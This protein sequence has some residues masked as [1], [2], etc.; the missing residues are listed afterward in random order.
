MKKLIIISLV[1]M[2]VAVAAHG[3]YLSKTVNSLSNIVLAN[4]EVRYVT[5]SCCVAIVDKV[6]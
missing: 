2:F 5:R 4:V 1:I 6:V 3:V